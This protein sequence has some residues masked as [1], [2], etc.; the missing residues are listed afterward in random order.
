MP[1]STCDQEND[2]STDVSPFEVK[3]VFADV[4]PGCGMKDGGRIGGGMAAKGVAGA[5]SSRFDG[6]C[7]WAMTWRGRDADAR[8]FSAK[9]CV[10]RARFREAL[11]GAPGGGS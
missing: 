11:L 9:D 3:D 10:D 7:S 6:I 4:V 1:C 8:I 5:L 2:V